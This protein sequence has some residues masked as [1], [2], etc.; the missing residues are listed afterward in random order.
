MNEPIEYR[1]YRIGETLTEELHTRVLNRE[2]VV[3]L[4]PRKSGKR[5]VLWELLQKLQ[6]ARTLIAI[7]LQF[8]LETPPSEARDVR[9]IVG[10]AVHAAAPGL[11]FPEPKRGD[12]LEQIDQLCYVQQRGVVLLASNVDCLPHHLAQLFLREVRKLVSA[13]TSALTVLLTG[14]ED[15]GGFVV[16]EDSEFNCTQQ[17]VIQG[18]GYA[19][20]KAWIERGKGI[21]KFPFGDEESCIQLL[22]KYTGGNIRV[23]RSAIDAMIEFRSRKGAPSGA[24]STDDFRQFLEGVHEVVVNDI[25]VF[26]QTALVVDRDPNG[27]KMARRLVD[28]EVVEPGPAPLLVELAGLAIRDGGRLSFASPIMRNFARSHYDSNHLGDLH[29]DAGEWAEAF[30]CYQNTQ[31]RRRP[32]TH[33]L[34]ERIR[35]T[36]VVERLV[37][38]IHGEATKSPEVQD[39]SW[40]KKLD[41]VTDLLVQGCRLVLGWPSVSSWTFSGDLR[42]ARPR[43]DWSCDWGCPEGS[44]ESEFCRRVLARSDVNVIGRQ[45]RKGAEPGARASVNIDDQGVVVILPSEWYDRRTAIVVCDVRHP[46]TLSPDRAKLLHELVDSFAVAYHHTI[47]NKGHWLRGDARKEHLEI[48]TEIFNSLG[49]SVKNPREALR[50]AGEKL[51]SRL[52]YYRRIAFALVDVGRQQI[53]GVADCPADLPGNIAVKTCYSLSDPMRDVQP[54]V[55]RYGKALIVDDW[56]QWNA[57]SDVPKVNRDLSSET[58]MKSCFAVLPMFF[59]ADGQ[60]DEVVGTIHIERRDGRSP[61]PEDIED[62]IQFGRQ[63]AAAIH[64]SECVNIL[65]ES[66]NLDNDSVVIVD[67]EENVVFANKAANNRLGLRAGWHKTTDNQKLPCDDNNAELAKLGVSRSIADNTS[68]AIYDGMEPGGRHEELKCVPLPDWRVQP[69]G[70]G[71]REAKPR[72]NGAVITIR[73][74]G[75]L[76]QVFAALQDVAVSAKK[77][78]RM[79]EAVLRSVE[80]LGYK[81]ARFYRVERPD[82]AGAE[83]LV[84]RLAVGMEEENGEEE[85]K[86]FAN[87]SLSIPRDEK[88]DA[89]WECIDQERP[90]IF[91]WNPDLPEGPPGL[92]KRM[93]S[94]ISYKEFHC[95]A[96]YANT[97]KKPGDV[98]IDFPLISAE[99]KPKG[100]ISVDCGKNYVSN[101]TPEQLEL[102]RLFSA[103]LGALLDVL[104]Q[105]GA[106]IQKAADRA[107]EACAHRIRTRFAALDGFSELYR[108]AAPENK[109][110]ERL[111]KLQ[112]PIVA[113][114]F[115]L[116][117]RIVKTFGDRVDAVPT[118]IKPF[119]EGILQRVLAVSESRKDV[120]WSLT[121]PDELCAPIDPEQ[122]GEVL[123]EMLSNSLQMRPKDRPLH[124]SCVAETAL[125]DMTKHLRLVVQD[126]G[127]GVPAAIRGQLFQPMVSL[128]PG[129]ERGTGQGLNFA[130]R[131]VEGHGGEIG[132]NSK[133]TDGAQ[134]VILLPF[135]KSKK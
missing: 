76:R 4:G 97:W 7:D 84:S 36:L 92:S 11:T 126:N 51:I 129:G 118:R 61:S 3:L 70:E 39:R 6:Q 99:R 108:I 124:I 110:V 48:A 75:T 62:L 69:E 18:F 102:L 35:L 9:K 74:L 121:A 109:R 37:A 15:L 13:P 83:L 14:E 82:L 65:E 22:Y 46:R 1:Y 88:R 103:L 95:T 50:K 89:S 117:D 16:G 2:S 73:N 66:L 98:W 132:L 26:Y 23:A 79:E 49:E 112:I 120:T 105:E 94:G 34:D 28:E 67:H 100:K 47:V 54:W 91:C 125:N 57:R 53:A 81:K 111:V 116:V 106:L 119:L 21:L 31:A 32:P 85:A 56:R 104:D 38:A 131:V 60:A 44:P 80:Q 96:Y 29:A 71:K 107:M 113:D 90:C 19:E 127:P 72:A 33:G 93:A 42:A 41:D 87:G 130:R 86:K 27:W 77:D 5:L 45:K 122:L 63:L 40:D 134:F 24:L 114:C 55:A 78:I 12:L 64:Q 43:G 101:L 10:R 128:R 58:G 135:E 59:K 115:H 25:D 123:W 30:Q 20:F 68:D 133:Y 17:F 52:T 8:P